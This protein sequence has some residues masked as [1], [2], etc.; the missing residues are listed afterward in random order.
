MSQRAESCPPRI[1]ERQRHIHTVPICVNIQ[2]A[3]DY[4]R[5][6]CLDGPIELL[7]ILFNYVADDDMKT[8]VEEINIATKITEIARCQIQFWGARFYEI[9]NTVC[10]DLK[11]TLA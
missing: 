6:F 5:K 8:R 7:T 11:K 1:G 9:V 2:L 10:D 4:C 3:I